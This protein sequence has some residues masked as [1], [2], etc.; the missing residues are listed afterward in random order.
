MLAVKGKLLAWEERIGL[1]WKTNEYNRDE[2][3]AR[4]IGLSSD[5][6]LAGTLHLGYLPD[7]A[8]SRSV[9]RKP[10]QQLITW[11]RQDDI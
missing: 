4:L 1:V 2:D 6:R 10:A 11:I 3:F 7:D 5:E 8:I 9:S